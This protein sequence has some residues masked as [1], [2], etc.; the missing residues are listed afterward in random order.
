MDPKTIEWSKLEFKYS[1][2]PYRFQARCQNGQ[3]NEGQLITENKISIDEGA[4]CLHYG[5]QIFEGMKAQRTKDGRIMLFRPRENA[6]RFR[7]SA[8]RILMAEVPEELFMKGIIETVKANVDY[9]PPYGTGA[10]LYIRP[11]E[12][13]VGE[14]L[15][16]KPAPEY[17][18]S[19]FVCPVGPYFKAGFKT[20]KLKVDDFYDRAALHGIGRAKAGGNYSASLFPLKIAREEGFNEIVYLDSVEHKYFEET[21]ASNVFF[22]FK[23][24]KLATPKSDS[25]LESITRLSLLKV[26]REEFGL[27]WWSGASALMKSKILRKPEP[28]A[29]LPSLRRSVSSATG[30]KCINYTPTGRKPARSLPSYIN[31]SR[32]I[33]SAMCPTASA[34][35]KKSVNRLERRDGFRQ[36]QMGRSR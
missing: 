8:R 23:N 24:G 7:R 9:V 34:G 14:N 31:I 29:L 6:D 18:F 30:E 10:S 26:A 19:V 11:F 27:T 15:G 25:I 28:A 3:W 33:R 22:V 36:F 35:W 21:G 20:I 12:I 17:I 1:Y 5:Q 13:G 16:V 4:T 2:T 32:P